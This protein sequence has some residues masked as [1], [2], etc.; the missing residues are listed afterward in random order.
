[1]TLPMPLIPNNGLRG[2]WFLKGNANDSS[3]FSNNGTGANI[4]YGIGKD[5]KY[6]LKVLNTDATRR[7]ASIPY[8]A[9]LNPT[10]G[11]FNGLPFSIAAQVINQNA[12]KRCVILSKEGAAANTFL[13]S[14]LNNKLQLILLTDIL[15]YVLIESVVSLKTYVSYNVAATYDGTG[16]NGMK[17][18]IDGVQVST[19]S[20]TVGTYS[21]MLV[22][23]NALR[24]GAREF[25]PTNDLEYS[26]AVF[27]AV[28]YY[29]RELSAK[30]IEE[31]GYIDRIKWWLYQLENQ[32][33]FNG[34]DTPVYTGS[35][36]LVRTG[37]AFTSGKNGEAS[38][39]VYFDGV[40]DYA[41]ITPTD[42]YQFSL[43][44]SNNEV[45]PVTVIFDVYM[46]SSSTGTFKEIFRFMGIDN[47]RWNINKTEFNRFVIQILDV[48][49]N[50][51]FAG[52]PEPDIYNKW[53]NVICTF[54]GVD[55]VATWVNGVKGNDTVVSGILS[56]VPTT[57]NVLTI[58]PDFGQFKL[59]NF[60]FYNRKLTDLEC[61]VLSKRVFDEQLVLQTNKNGTFNATVTNSGA[62][63]VYEE[64]DVK[65]YTNSYSKTFTGQGNTVQVRATG[66]WLGVLEFFCNSGG[67]LIEFPNYLINAINITT[68]ELQNNAGIPAIPNE[69]GNLT[70]LET[71]NLTNNLVSAIPSGISGCVKLTALRL[72]GNQNTTIPIE[73]GD[74]PLLTTLTADYNLLTSVNTNL[75]TKLTLATLQ[76]NNNQLSQATLESCL[77]SIPL[78]IAPSLRTIRLEGNTG[79]VAT[80]ISRATLIA[81]L[82]ANYNYL[83]TI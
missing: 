53:C 50:N 79:S 81:N 82:N 19:T 34:V 44:N 41:T 20:G 58:A 59:D 31:I 8:S 70:K 66:D 69:I 40:D 74:L 27:D 37:A 77:D 35:N 60:Y 2:A 36:N 1:M 71:L 67:G 4:S 65:V 47:Q 30:E 29:N 57:S 78:T 14:I 83:I 73:V 61:R 72:T 5:G 49:S 16:I 52:N 11:S 38:G 39:A 3:G 46:Y 54:D 15:N 22:N 17:L 25:Y 80:A 68:I 9:D 45:R 63:L 42:N 75:F 7:Y 51:I 33:K 23:T 48:N 56:L 26:N 28:L 62:T 13:F 55:K 24:I 64:G 43:F 32:Y 76:L 12:S 18:Y 6:N 21:G 10:N